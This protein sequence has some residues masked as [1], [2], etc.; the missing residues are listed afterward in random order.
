MGDHLPPRATHPSGD[1]ATVGDEVDH[2]KLLDQPEGV[3]PEGKDVAE[4]DYLGVLGDAGEDGGLDV[5]GAA[6]AEGGGVVLIEH[7]AVEPRFV[8]VDFFVEVA[9]IEIGADLRVV[10][11]VAEGQ[12]LDG[13]AGSPEIA[14]LWVLIGSLG[15][16][17]Y[18]HDVLLPAATLPREGLYTGNRG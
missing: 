10:D 4:E 6:H 3:V 2:G 11:L 13:Q 12:V 9:V 8:G 1:E 17:T 5:G 15:K 7:K 14:G 18:E 16:V